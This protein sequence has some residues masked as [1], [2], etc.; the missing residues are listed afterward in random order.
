MGS[1]GA[2]RSG[3]EGRSLFDDA[4]DAVSS[5]A[6]KGGLSS[7]LSSVLDVA[8]D[9]VFSCA[10]DGAASFDAVDSNSSAT[11]GGTI[12]VDPILSSLLILSSGR[13]TA[14]SCCLSPESDSSSFTLDIALCISW[15]TCESLSIVVFRYFSASC[16]MASSDPLMTAAALPERLRFHK[17]TTT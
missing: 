12:I 11:S 5:D 3:S 9:D 14:F 15:I 8:L 16:S 6:F 13:V 10:K 1:S 4:K 7:S 17:P 2:G